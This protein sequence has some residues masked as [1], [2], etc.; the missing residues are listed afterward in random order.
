[1][2]VSEQLLPRW[3]LIDW[4][5]EVEAL[6]E[7]ST[8]SIELSSVEKATW[9]HPGRTTQGLT[10]NPL[11]IRAVLN[12]LEL[13]KRKRDSA[14]CVPRSLANC[15]L[16]HEQPGFGLLNGDNGNV[17][18]IWKKGGSDF[19][20][21]RLGVPTIGITMNEEQIDVLVPIQKGSRS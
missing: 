11:G 12:V 4:A 8:E 18:A 16:I 10:Q 7:R 17:A 21:P 1:M 14:P 13:W 19:S 5:V 6:D 2:N 3:Q 9:L 15:V 20:P